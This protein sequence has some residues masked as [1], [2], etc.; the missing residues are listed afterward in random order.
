MKIDP[1][2]WFNIANMQFNTQIQTVKQP[3]ISL[4][5]AVLYMS[6]QYTVNNSLKGSEM[7]VQ[8]E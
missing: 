2:I 1:S 5:V 6:L 8:T 7:I 4:F 3:M